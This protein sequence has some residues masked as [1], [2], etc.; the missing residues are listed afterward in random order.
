MRIFEA[1]DYPPGRIIHWLLTV[2]AQLPGGGKVVDAS[3]RFLGALVA[4]TWSMKKKRNS[5]T[6]SVV[7][8]HRVVEKAEK[9]GN[10]EAGHYFEV[11]EKAVRNWHKQ[12]DVLKSM[13][14]KRSNRHRKVKW[15]ALEENLLRWALDQRNVGRSIST[16]KI[17]LR[18]KSMAEEMQITDFKG[19]INWVYRFIHRKNLRVRSR[20]TMCQ[21]FRMT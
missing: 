11:D 8:Q 4:S 9:D 19:G 21:A 15:P 14:R 16:V 17:R 3:A 18:A 2:K 6:Y 12:K 1:A 10:R 5:F 20:T 7:W 13:G